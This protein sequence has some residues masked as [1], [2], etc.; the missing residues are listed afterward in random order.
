M[1][2]SS[3]VLTLSLAA[4]FA[5]PALVS[6][7]EPGRGPRT[8]EER[9]KAL[10]ESLKL[11]DEQAEKLKAVFA[12]NQEKTKALRDDK[13]LSAEDRRAKMREASDA[14]DAEVKP[15]LTPEQQTK[16]KEETEKR[17]AERAKRQQ[18]N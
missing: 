18:N 8:P 12:K 15:I 11:S 17:R 16:W 5:V 3:I 10:K 7:Q 14:L 4:L 6:A 9:V 13:A 1:K 2:K